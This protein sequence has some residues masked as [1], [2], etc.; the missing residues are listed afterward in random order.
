MSALVAALLVASPA[1]AG[2]PN[3]A[4]DKCAGDGG[5]LAKV[6]ACDSNLGSNTLVGSFVP[7]ADI[8]GVTGFE[9]VLD[10]LLGDGISPA[11]PWWDLKA[12]S[13]GCR[14]MGGG[15]AA[16]LSANSVVSPTAVSC[17]DWAGG[18]ASGG[19]GAYLADGSNVPP[20]NQLAHRR[21]V[22]GFAV[23]MVN[24]TDLIATQEYFAFN[25]VI[26]NYKTIGTGSCAG[27]STPACFVINALNVVSGTVGRQTLYMTS[28][29]ATWQ[30]SGPDCGIV[31]TR[32]ATWTAVKQLYH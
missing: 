31:P 25:L 32:R 17:V 2:G 12:G 23:A 19:L 11:P 16:A 1:L 28:N 8:A 9:C 15:V 21:V 29:Y 5:Q 27:C 6:S 22:L 4:W 26:S 7:N 18:F 3:L 14:D 30:T 20:A 10:I 13:G 24:A